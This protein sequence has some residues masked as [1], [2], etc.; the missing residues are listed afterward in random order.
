MIPQD[1]VASLNLEDGTI[2]GAPPVRRYLAD[3]ARVFGDA[4]QRPAQVD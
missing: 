3:L 2:P 4:F 1:L